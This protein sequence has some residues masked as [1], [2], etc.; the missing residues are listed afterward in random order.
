MRDI[1]AM[2]QPKPMIS[3]QLNQYNPKNFVLHLIQ[4]A[5]HITT[6]IIE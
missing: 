3:C 6:Y 1:G 4:T 2:F 5:P